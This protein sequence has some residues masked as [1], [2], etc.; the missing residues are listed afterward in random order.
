VGE[1]RKLTLEEVPVNF[2]DAPTATRYLGEC[3]ICEREHKLDDR[4]L[5]VHHGHRRP[6]HGSI[7]GDC[8]GV[9]YPPYERSCELCK[10]VLA[11]A[12]VRLA[13]VRERI[14]GLQAGEI[15]MVT[16]LRR[17]M[18][19]SHELETLT[20]AE[21]GEAQWSRVVR[22]HVGS[23]ERDAYGLEQHIRHLEKRIADW[24]LRPISTI[25]ERVLEERGNRAARAAERAAAREARDLRAAHTALKKRQL[26]ERRAA[27]RREFAEKFRALAASASRGTVDADPLEDRQRAARALAQE[28]RKKKYSFLY[29][30]ELDADDAL[31]TLGLAERVPGMRR[32]RY[33]YPLVG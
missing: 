10:E 24:Q 5:L 16:R 7:V 31:V 32:P 33:R 3:Q 4:E 27:V 13:S 15:T 20:L 8:P 9:A 30:W 1:A 21:L 25:E 14:R 6:G 29:A 28:M 11:G 22:D 2:Q 26:E 19:G 12:R 18:G 23:L 17:R